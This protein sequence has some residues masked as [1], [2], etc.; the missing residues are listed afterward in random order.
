MSK[1]RIFTFVP[2]IL[3]IMLA[4]AYSATGA[5]S[6]AQPRSLLAPLYSDLET[7]PTFHWRC[8]TVRP[9]PHRAARPIFRWR[10]TPIRRPK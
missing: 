8:S 2:S 9:R 6:R 3:L 1:T 10:T 7:Y 5:G 4:L